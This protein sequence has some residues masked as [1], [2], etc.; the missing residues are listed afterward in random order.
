MNT[1]LSPR[2]DEENKLRWHD[3]LTGKGFKTWIES[4]TAGNVPAGK[5]LDPFTTSNR[6]LIRVSAW[7]RGIQDN[8]AVGA[9]TDR[10]EDQAR[11]DLGRARLAERDGGN[12]RLTELGV[13]VL[14]TWG[15][16]AI[17][18]DAEKHEIARALVLA[19]HAL[20]SNDPYYMEAM[21]FWRE[22]REVYDVKTLFDTPEAMALIG[23]LNQKVEDFNPW[24]VI[25]G[26][27]VGLDVDLAN[28]WQDVLTELAG[29]DPVFTAATDKLKATVM[30]WSGR[31]QGR[32]AFC[33][34]LEVLC[35]PLAEAAA[36]LISWGV[37]QE[38]TDAAVSV[39]TSLQGS[40][41][42]DPELLRVEQLIMARS[43]VILYGPPGTGKTRAAFLI[44]DD[45]RSKYGLDSVFNVTFHPSYGYEDFVQGY[46]PDPD[47]PGKFALGDGVLLKAARAAEDALAANPG[48]PK[49]FLMVIDEINR[50]ETAR[51]FGELITYIE[52]DKRGVP[53]ELAQIEKGVRVIPSNLYFLGTMNTSDKSINLLD[54]A[55]RRR[56]ASVGMPPKPE[57]FALRDDWATSVDGIDLASLLVKLNQSLLD[58]GVEPDRALGHALL[59]IDA[60][61]PDPV[62]ALRERLEFDVYPL[63]S[64]YCYMNRAAIAEVL[65][66]LVTNAGDWQEMDNA[67]F[68]TSLKSL[69]RIEVA[70]VVADEPAIDDDNPGQT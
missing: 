34:A 66:R 24:D 44:A 26:A 22:V 32:V 16:H 5:P 46:R 41:I 65:G 59:K 62:K 35:T 51:I 7:L 13:N 8:G 17:A 43:N 63:V 50:G 10:T 9:N 64:E 56:F 58:Q 42:T 20:Q 60:V 1:Y 48:N 69:L 33:M 36:A 37:S 25:R 52:S 15:S 19:H 47:E 49:N 12:V 27:R 3:V 18:D 53:F 6:R 40:S 21:G 57:T 11:I 61:H 70:A 29:G 38:E 4:I 39:W 54:V 23:Y 67:E 45:W 55:L 31:S 28:D 68:T 2:F 14:S 30:G